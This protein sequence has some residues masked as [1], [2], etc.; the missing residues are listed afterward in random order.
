LGGPTID[1]RRLGDAF[2]V[3]LTSLRGRLVTCGHHFNPQR[4][5]LALAVP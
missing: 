1:S 2:T 4:S 3:V 5:W